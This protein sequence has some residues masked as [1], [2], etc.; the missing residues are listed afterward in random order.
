MRRM[1][2]VYNNETFKSY[3]ERFFPNHRHFYT[4][5]SKVITP[6]STSCAM[7]SEFHKL[8]ECWKLRPEHSV[9][10]SELYAILQALLFLQRNPFPLVI[11]FTDSQSALYMLLKT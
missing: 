9:V 11:L 4:D 6:L 5:G 3:S 2:I 1:F 10:H 8:T 7:Y